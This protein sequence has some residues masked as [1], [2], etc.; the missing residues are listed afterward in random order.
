MKVNITG[1]GIIPGIGTLAP[2]Y[3]IEMDKAAIKRIL[4][5]P[6]Y[7]QLVITDADTNLVITSRNLDTFFGKKLITELPNVK[8]T[9][10]PKQQ[11]VVVHEQPIVETKPIVKE[12]LP[13]ITEPDMVVEVTSTSEKIGNVREVE[14]ESYETPEITIIPSTTDETTKT[15]K[16]TDNDTFKKKKKHGK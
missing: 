3:H 6:H 1:K 4:D 9:Q 11:P 2:K 12:V 16:S 8:P 10:T 14:Q 13:E 7:H 15:E 5:F